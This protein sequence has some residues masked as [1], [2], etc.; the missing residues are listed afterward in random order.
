MLSSLL[1]GCLSWEVDPAWPPC[2]NKFLPVYSCQGVLQLGYNCPHMNGSFLGGKFTGRTLVW[3]C[4]LDLVSEDLCGCRTT[5]P[6]LTGDSDA[7]DV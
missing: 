7:V 3:D 6:G 5:E 2:D 1:L 4:S